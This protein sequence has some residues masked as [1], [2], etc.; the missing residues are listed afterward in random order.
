MKTFQ[1]LYRSLLVSLLIISCTDSAELLQQEELL[2]TTD[3]NKKEIALEFIDLMKNKKFKKRTLELLKNEKVGV[4][5]SE[6]LNKNSSHINDQSAFIKL[7]KKSAELERKAI[8][9]E[10]P[11]KIEILEIWLHNPKGDTDFS[12]LLF[13]FAPKGNEKD[14][15]SVIAYDMDKN[16]IVLDAKTSPNRPII[17]IEENGIE[18]LKKEVDQMNRLLRNSGLQKS[19]FDPK[20]ADE[21]IRASQT[22]GLETTKLDKIRLNHD[23]ESWILGAAEVYA[24]TSGIRSEDNSPEIKVITMEY[25]DH[26]GTDY[27]PNQILL[28]WDDYQYQA[29][30][31]QF[32]EKDDS[33]NYKEL[34]QTIINGV[35]Q[36]LGTV[37]TQPWVNV[38]GQVAGAILE[39][40]PEEWFRNDDDYVDSLY[41]IEKNKSYTNYFGARGNAKV[42]LSPFYVAPN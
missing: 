16:T 4:L 11:E 23:E 19:S 1:F 6:I 37:A 13:S 7:S 24:I 34:T 33:G 5:L 38:L 42:N 27:Y 25:L 26:E 8:S 20:K 30:N 22:G 14:W 40:M 29:A 31:I 39:A 41:T 17:V 18:A 15:G 28:F 21:N 12:N 32:F 36:I 35:F 3:V 10:A 2:N 9:E